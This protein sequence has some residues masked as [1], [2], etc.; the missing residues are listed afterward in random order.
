MSI[1]ITSVTYERTRFN[2]KI[3]ENV[4]TFLFIFITLKCYVIKI[5]L[6]KEDIIVSES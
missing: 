1:V 5:T 6:V 2:K 3:H 4:F